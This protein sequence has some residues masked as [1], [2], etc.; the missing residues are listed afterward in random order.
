MDNALLQPQRFGKPLYVPLPNPDEHGL[1]LTALGRKKRIDVN[2]D[3]MAIE[4]D[5]ACKISVEPTYLLCHTQLTQPNIKTPIPPSNPLKREIFSAS[6][7]NFLP[8]ATGGDFE[9]IE[10]SGY[11]RRCFANLLIVPEG[12]LRQPFTGIKLSN[13]SKTETKGQFCRKKTMATRRPRIPSAPSS[14]H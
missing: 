13:D 9:A 11:R 6:K 5:S 1:I 2:V 7:Q 8:A 10:E 4:S 3:L 14:A 12:E